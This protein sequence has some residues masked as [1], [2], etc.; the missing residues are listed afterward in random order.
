MTKFTL[1]YTAS[2]GEHV[3]VYCQSQST[4]IAYKYGLCFLNGEMNVECGLNSNIVIAI[5]YE[6]S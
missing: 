5:T 3:L 4:N 1:W 6:M 2:A